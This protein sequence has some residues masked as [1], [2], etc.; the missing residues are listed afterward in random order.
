[1]G[2]NNKR[3]FGEGIGLSV[4]VVELGQPHIYLQIFI[5]SKPFGGIG[6]QQG[7]HINGI[8]KVLDKLCAENFGL[9]PVLSARRGLCTYHITATC[10]NI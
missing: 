10:Q 9:I 1:M 4:A 7:R 6:R 2:K 3:S 5:K 8:G